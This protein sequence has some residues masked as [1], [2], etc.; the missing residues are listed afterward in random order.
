MRKDDHVDPLL[1]SLS[2][3]TER[4]GKSYSVEALTADLPVAPGK[5]TAEMFSPH[6]SKAIFSRAAARAGYK[7]KLVKRPLNKI[8]P[9]VLPCIITLREQDA[10]ILES[11]DHERDEAKIIMPDDGGTEMLIDLKSLKHE[12]LGYAFY[13]KKE[14][15]YSE[16]KDPLIHTQQESWFWGSLRHSRKIYAD[17]IIASLVINLFVL[18]S[19]LFTM[20]VYDRVVPNNATETLFA[21]AIGVTVVYVID[22][23]LKFTRSYFLEM[24]GKK[25]DVI[26]S[27][28]LFQKVMNL[29]FSAVPE[30]VG[31]F[32]N[33]LKEFDSIRSFL[34]TSTLALLIDLPFTVI[35]LGVV[36]IIGGNIVIIPILFIILVVIYAFSIKGPL[37][38]S[39]ESTYHAN[40][41]KNSILIESLNALETIKTLGV[42]NHSQYAWEEATGDVASKGLA[43]RVLSNSIGSVTSFLMQLS[44]VAILVAGVYMIKDLELS[45]GGLIAVVILSSRALA[46]MGQVASLSANYE[47]TKTA[48][49]T[50][51]NIMQLPDERPVNKEFLHPPQFY[52]S[53]EF[54]DVTFTY[55]NE[56]KPILENISFTIKPGERVGLIGKMGSGKTTIMKL[57]LGLYTPDSGSILIDNID[58]QQIDPADLRKHIG[59]VA[60]DITLF[61]GT[62]KSNI[63]AKAPYV[64]DGDILRAAKIAGVDD[65]VQHHPK[66]FD[67]PVRERG[68]GISGGQRQSIAVARA[69]VLDAPMLLMDEPVKS[70]DEGA[71]V[72]MLRNLAEHTKEKTLIVSTHSMSTLK[73]VER[74]LVMDRGKIL[75]DGPK[76]EIINTLMKNSQNAKRSAS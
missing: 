21:L 64:D 70:M 14:F 49:N 19:P 69:F 76:Q 15:D 5:A 35:F 22:I 75:A 11:I 34:A 29:N 65:F 10:C 68:D 6:K 8:S 36:Y 2:I 63:I 54:K 12:Y 51:N 1:V 7:S 67:M 30:S 53:I 9:L 26:I 55:P 43:S 71:S 13:L 42:G 23:V 45:M 56:S 28:I 46:P 40:S 60:Q 32:A 16:H 62:V 74:V 57:L 41:Y 38:R 59:Y 27:S 3:F 39:V 50:L 20:N 33:N 52:G 17:V 58:I 24:A 72:R 73:I 4:Y 37:Q 48:F 18:A 47:H 66:G 31:S 44:N 25:S 61:K